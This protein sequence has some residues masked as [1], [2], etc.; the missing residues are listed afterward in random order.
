M[1]TLFQFTP[2]WDLPNVSPFCM[3]L[4]VYLRLAKI[5]YKVK[6]VNN[7]SRGPKGK[8]P[9]IKDNDEAMA[10]SGL[11]I[12]YLKAKYGDPLDHDLTHA[13]QG[14]SRAL[15]RLLEEHLYWV[16][17]YARWIEPA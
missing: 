15:Q 12:D 6:Y 3:K 1:I 13:Q 7:P 5:P 10:D 2:L 14:E 11:I 16:M 8:L 17:L 4:E 9:F